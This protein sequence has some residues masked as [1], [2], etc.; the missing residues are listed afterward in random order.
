M[1]SYDSIFK[2]YDVRGTVPDQFDAEM[3]RAIGGAF[4]RFAKDREGATRILVARDMR[5]SGVELTAAFTEGAIA[6]G[7]DVIDLGLTS[8]DLIYFASGQLDAPGAMFTASHNPAQYNGIK[9]CLSGAKP[10]GQ[11]SGL[12]DIKA[13]A[14]AGDLEPPA[15]TTTGTVAQQD[16]LGAYADHVIGF[17]DTS[18]L[19]PLKVIADT[20]NGMGGLVVPE[21]FAKLPFDI[22]ILYPELDG[23]FPNHPAD[24]IQ[25]ENLRD[26]QA[27]VTETGAD[28]GLAFDGDADRVFLVDEKADPISGSTTTAMVAKAMLEKKPGSTILYNLICSKSVPEIV[29]E[30]G[31]TPIKTRVG[32]SFIK[33]KMA[34]TG[35]VFGGEHSGHYYFLDNYR[36]DSGLI[37][38]VVILEL[39]SKAGAPL[40]EVRKPFER[41]AASGEINTEVDDQKAVMERVAAAYPDAQHDTLDGLT[42]DSGNW[43]FNLRP[44]N[45]EPLLR[46]NL[47]APTREECDARVAEVRALITGGN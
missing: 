11:D 16:M 25:P 46:L 38:A 29:G 27:K 37:A 2:A 5:P 45:T 13:M 15:G 22:E 47:E 14:A 42:I 9:F 6:Q 26:L 39:L 8:T 4:A 43:W 24:P 20:A 30:N 18:V 12:A 34:E 32:H 1:G 3:A 44:S 35:A 33:E 21:V 17:I 40:S 36:A 10:V 23:T 31:G 7:V 28:I 41:Y 19:R